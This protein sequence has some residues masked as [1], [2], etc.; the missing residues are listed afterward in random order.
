MCCRLVKRASL[1]VV[2]LAVIGMAGQA[3]AGFAGS[4]L[5]SSSFTYKYEM[6]AMPST[7]DLDGN[8]VMDFDA[9]ESAAGNLSVASGIATIVAGSGGS[10]YFG[11]ESAGKIWQ[12]KFAGG[13]FTI[14]C[15]AKVVSAVPGTDMEGAFQV[16]ASNGNYFGIKLDTS[17]TTTSDRQLLSSADNTDAFHVFR[18]A[19]QGSSLY[20]WRDGAPVGDGV[21]TWPVTYTSMYFGDGGGSIE[22]VTQVDYFRVTSGAYAPVPEPSSIALLASAIAGLLAYA[23]RKSR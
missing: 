1:I 5:D 13:D 16:F 23:W 15:A 21:T 19:Q 4:A 7:Q 2:T 11:S 10:D 18:F 17:K 20:V 14:E 3:M 12:N 9:N 22:G 6:D 8:S